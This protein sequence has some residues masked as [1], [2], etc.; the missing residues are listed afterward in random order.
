MTADVLRKTWTELANKEPEPP[1]YRLSLEIAKYLVE[2]GET[3]LFATALILC[4]T[5]TYEYLRAS[6]VLQ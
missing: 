1:T 2:R 6:G 5:E 4:D 3:R